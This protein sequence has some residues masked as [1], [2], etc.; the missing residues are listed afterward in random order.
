MRLIGLMFI[1]T[2]AVAGIIYLALA[3]VGFFT[4]V[5]G[6]VEK[7]SKPFKEGDKLKDTQKGEVNK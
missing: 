3:R 2:L 7:G 5:G 1:I 4:L 6:W